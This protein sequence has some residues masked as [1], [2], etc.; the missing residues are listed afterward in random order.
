MSTNALLEAARVAQLYRSGKVAYAASPAFAALLMLV[1][2]DP[3]TAGV[4]LAWYVAIVGVAIGRA[5]IHRR[6]LRGAGDA[7]SAPRWEREFSA[8]AFAAGA[9]W[10]FAPAVFF[11][12]VTPPQQI[13]IILMV[14]GS[15]I[16]AAGLYAASPRAFA[17]YALLPFAATLVQLLLVPD[18]LYRLMALMLVLFAGILLGVYRDIR[19]G[20]EAVLRF[21]LENE[22]LA[23][24]L[25]ASEG[26]LRDALESYP[27]GIA[28]YDGE[29]RLLICN[30]EYAR[31]Y[32]AGRRAAE[33]AGT[34][35]L[36]IARHAFEAES[37][38]PEFAGRR[39][40]WI[41]ERLARRRAGTGEQRLYQTRDGRW[42][43]GRFVRS[44]SGGIL[45]VFSDVS[46]LKRAQERYLAVLAEE[47]LVLDTLPVGVAFVEDRIIV[48]C[49][50][51][52]EEMLGY[53]AGELGG[54]PAA[55]LF[56]GAADWPADGERALARKDGS[57]IWGALASRAVNTQAPRESA[58][59]ALSDVTER[60]EAERALRAS[61]SMYRNLVETS[62]D[63]VWTLD[64]EGQWRYL[65]PA[66]AR[67]IY[68]YAPEEL[69]GRPM[70]ERA[71]AEV[72]GRD[73]AVFER[74]LRGE[75]VFNYETR[76]LRRDGSYADLAFNAIPLRDASGA[77]CGATGTARDI[78]EDKA[79]AAAQQ[80]NIEKLRLAVEAADLYYWEWDVAS[81]LLQ[82]G[83][84]PGPGVPGAVTRIDWAEYAKRVHPEDRERYV[85]AGRAAIERGEP[86]A[87]EYRI[88]GRNGRVRWLAARG[89][90]L[91]DAS[92]RTHRL[93]G[94]SQ[95][96]TERKRQEDE[97]RFLA[98][99]DVLTG[100]PNRRLLDD[101]L[102]QALHLA[103][104]RDSRVAV[105]LVDLD[106]FKVVNDSLGHRAGDAVLREAG[107]RLSDCVRKA[108]TLARHG[109]DEFVIVVPDL[110]AESDCQV[111][112]EKV[113]RAFEA[114]FRVDG[115][116]FLLGAS[117]GISIYPADAGDGEA[118]LRN[119]DVAM[120]RAKQ[121][122][123][124]HYLFY[125]R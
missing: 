107:H 35:Y 110:Q 12:E 73:A 41:E 120:Y 85:A 6:Y 116:E 78:S 43:Q 112:A 52:L 72:A 50:R 39:E 83:Q 56:A 114:P 15:L 97:A 113:L 98:Y 19:R 18:N 23:R 7:A 94:V 17:A 103:R 24:R 123:K 66:A 95:D 75:P 4:L 61:E 44:R 71:V 60:H 36:D 2:W 11:G 119:A 9:V 125:R 1:L 20:A 31:V 29:D 87:V 80:E 46:E 54:K 32:G 96:V 16:G 70:R 124:N 91:A 57:T 13:A 3:I 45:S 10:A 5:A 100:L 59:L 118:L 74:V 106:R 88:E 84:K 38:P 102:A 99:H 77:L 63:L 55:A 30:E 26:R 34:P 22:D 65:S 25:G 121:L 111:V 90:P 105:M 28:V 62:N 82:Y 51:R 104:R 101:R 49:N 14:G 79:A 122:G 40:D 76:H 68:G 67:R 93:I 109:G 81:G 47:N 53:G 64:R 27:D 33:L 86:Y 21:G 92:G 37:V 42:M 58:I 48:R 115:R 69:R 8:G 89:K 108:D 117:I